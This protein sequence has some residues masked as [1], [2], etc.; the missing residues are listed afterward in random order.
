MLKF[1]CFDL[2]YDD[3]VAMGNVMLFRET[4]APYK[5]MHAWPRNLIVANSCTAVHSPLGSF[6]ETYFV[7]YACLLSYES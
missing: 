7:N 3:S 1:I 6:G 5:D 2:V 4:L